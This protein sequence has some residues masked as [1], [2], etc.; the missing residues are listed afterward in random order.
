MRS[1]LSPRTAVNS[2]QRYYGPIYGDKIAQNLEFYT[3]QTRANLQRMRKMY[4]RTL[5]GMG[6]TSGMGSVGVD[7][8]YQNKAIYELEKEDDSFGSGIF[9]PPG[10]TGTSNPDAGVFS[11]SY[12][13]PGYIARGVPFTV[14]KDVKDI[15]S[16][17]DVVYVPGG[18]M[19]YV[20]RNGRLAGPL[21]N[22]M[23]HIVPQSPAPV[24]PIPSSPATLGPVPFN[25]KRKR[26][27]KQ[28]IVFPRQT[29]APVNPVANPVAHAAP[30]MPIYPA[31]PFTSTVNVGPTRPIPISGFGEEEEIKEPA[32]V[33]Q[34]ALAGAAVGVAAAL[35]YGALNAK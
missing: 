6:S 20:E 15:N 17:A 31:V 28:N 18:G 13:L 23:S 19:A 26:L 24:G 21:H 10:R 4:G 3:G 22:P 12:D 5:A 8:G 16:G 1:R 33:G 32:T 2:R 27:P 14:S 11:S 7:P 29:P 34:L 35:V 9:D 25:I 30:D